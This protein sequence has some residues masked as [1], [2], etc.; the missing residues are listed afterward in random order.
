MSALLSILSLNLFILH[1]LNL[2]NASFLWVISP[3]FETSW[4]TIWRYAATFQSNW[5]KKLRNNKVLYL[6]KTS[7]CRHGWEGDKQETT[8]RQRQTF[9]MY[10]GSYRK[11]IL[12]LV[13]SASGLCQVCRQ[14]PTGWRIDTSAVGRCG[15]Y[16]LNIILTLYALN[17]I[18]TPYAL[19]IILTLYALN[20]ILT[21]YALNIT[22]YS[23]DLCTTLTAI[24]HCNQMET[25][26]REF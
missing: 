4:Q 10:S 16:A 6:A 17:M 26:R 19:N 12:Q 9:L 25:V 21:P 3:S 7:C 14:W 8:Q 2:K 13:V 23:L 18:L 5:V 20:M 24:I 22:L 15:E 1:L 11:G